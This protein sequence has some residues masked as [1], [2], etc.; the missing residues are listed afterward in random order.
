MTTTAAH[1]VVCLLE[2]AD[3]VKSDLMA[4]APDEYATEF[5]DEQGRV[6]HVKTNEDER[7]THMVMGPSVRFGRAIQPGGTICW[8][9]AYLAL[10]LLDNRADPWFSPDGLPID[11][12]HGIYMWGHDPESYLPPEILNATKRWLVATM[13]HLVTLSKEYLARVASGEIMF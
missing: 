11:R 12:P 8:W 3:E 13:P 10:T 2:D 4:S 6:W 5:T 7:Y 1:I 9:P